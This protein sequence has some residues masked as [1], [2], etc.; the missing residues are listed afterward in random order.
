MQSLSQH[1]ELY[2]IKFRAAEGNLDSQ[3]SE[4]VPKFINYKRENRIFQRNFFGSKFIMLVLLVIMILQ[5]TNALTDNLSHNKIRHWKSNNMNHLNNPSHSHKPS[6]KDD[7]T[8]LMSME[9]SPSLKNLDYDNGARCLINAPIPDEPKLFYYYDTELP[10]GILVSD[11]LTHKLASNVLKVFIEEILG[12]VNVTLVSMADPSQG[13]DPD[14][15]F[16]Y[17]SSCTDPKYDFIMI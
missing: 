12:Y 4:I 5:T 10:I 15:Q 7:S 6:S 17:V 14:T 11:R 3:R 9:R 16:S 2:P 8:S 13:F 1:E